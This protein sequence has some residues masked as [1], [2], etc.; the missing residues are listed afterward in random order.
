ML[1]VRQLLSFNVCY[2][3]VTRIVDKADL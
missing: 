2:H 3:K 1:L